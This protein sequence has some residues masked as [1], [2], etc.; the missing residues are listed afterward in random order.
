VIPALKRA[1]GLKNCDQRWIKAKL[2][3]PMHSRMGR[4]YFNRAVLE[5]DGGLWTAGDPGSQK[6]S[7]FLNFAVVNG[8]V[9]LPETVGDVEA[10]S[11]VDALHFGLELGY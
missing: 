3:T 11:M 10:G 1:G 8:L 2:T 5:L 9:L 6:T 4:L 7:H